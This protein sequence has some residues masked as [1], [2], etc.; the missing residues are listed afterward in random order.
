MDYVEVETARKMPGVK[1]ALTR[2]G[3]PAPWGQAARKILEYKRISY[4]PV[5]QKPARPNEELF[6]WTGFRNAPVL[7]YEDTPAKANWADI[8]MLAERLAPDRPLVPE[9]SSDRAVLFGISAEI[10][11]E[12]GFGWSRRLMMLA[13]SKTVDDRAMPLKRAYGEGPEATAAAAKRCVDILAMLADRLHAQE[14]AGSPF[15]VGDSFTAADLYWACFS[16]MLVPLPLDI[17]PV[18]PMM[19]AVYAEIGPLIEQS[20]HPILLRHRDMVFE[21]HIGLPLI[22]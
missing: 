13:D 9:G 7:I 3:S 19:H 10:C 16:S 21:D 17:C 4:I 15:F 12:G 11:G 14:A 1:L 2:T 22:Q 6:A 8:L 20:Y 18:D 5:L